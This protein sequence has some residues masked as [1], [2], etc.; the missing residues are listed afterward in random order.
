MAWQ[1]QFGAV[2][3]KLGKKGKAVGVGVGPTSHQPELHLVREE[4]IHM[5]QAISEGL[6]GVVDA[7]N[8][9][10]KV[11]GKAQLANA[12][13]AVAGDAGQASD[14]AQALAGYLSWSEIQAVLNSI[15]TAQALTLKRIKLQASELISAL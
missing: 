5:Q 6:Q 14:L 8:A 3:K 9:R 7:V 4:V 1:Q 10:L 15:I 11:A 2:N 13:R 12:T